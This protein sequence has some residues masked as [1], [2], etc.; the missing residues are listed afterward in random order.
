MLAPTV[1]PVVSTSG[2]SPVTVTVSCTADG[3]ICRFTT[4]VWPMRICIERFA[5][6][7]PDSSAAMR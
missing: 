6:A 3:D 7:K 4:A 1:D 2:A 5:V